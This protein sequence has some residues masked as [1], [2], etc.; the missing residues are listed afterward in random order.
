MRTEEEIREEL[1]LVE[2][3]D[4]DISSGTFQLGEVSGYIRALRWALGEDGDKA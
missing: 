2:S 4:M 1:E 3:N